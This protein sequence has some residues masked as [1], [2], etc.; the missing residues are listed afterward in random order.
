MREARG[1][2]RVILRR[3]HKI[4]QVDVHPLDRAEIE[5]KVA[6]VDPSAVRDVP[7]ID[8]AHRTEVVGVRAERRRHPLPR[9][10][11]HAQV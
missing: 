4:L 5:A 11:L 7:L 2:L 3:V 9:V 1:E 8:V 10:G 6:V